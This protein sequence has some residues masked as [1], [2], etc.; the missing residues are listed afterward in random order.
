MQ[1]SILPE[2]TSEAFSG[3]I[4]GHTNGR[5]PQ[6]Y[7]L[8]ACIV[9][10]GFAGVYLLH[11]LR[12]EGF[13]VKIVDDGTKIGGV[14]TSTRTIVTIGYILLTRLFIDSRFGIGTLTRKYH[15]PRNIYPAS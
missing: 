8:D 9:G 3:H 1:T 7:E 4:N 10:A 12:Q 14:C 6:H 5:T 15:G 13:N 11:R 2:T